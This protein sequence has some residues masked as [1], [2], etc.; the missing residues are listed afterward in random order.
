MLCLR[1]SGAGSKF[2]CL[3]LLASRA[4]RMNGASSDCLVHPAHVGPMLGRDQISVAVLDRGLESTVQRL[5]R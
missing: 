3:R 4:V 5:R 2:R 1:G